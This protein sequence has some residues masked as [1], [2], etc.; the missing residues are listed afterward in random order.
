M[1][2]GSL[3]PFESMEISAR[4]ESREKSEWIYWEEYNKEMARSDARLKFINEHKSDIEMA[5]IC[6]KN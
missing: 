1:F 2:C 6:I 3:D 4:A 5:K